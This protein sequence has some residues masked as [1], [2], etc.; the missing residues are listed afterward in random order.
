MTRSLEF[1][2]A[3]S[4]LGLVAASPGA[5]V[6]QVG[7]V[8]SKCIVDAENA[9]AEANWI[10]VIRYAGPCGSS[11]KALWLMGQAE[12]KL[13]RWV[14]AEE[15]LRAA[16]AMAGDS[17]VEKNR[18][19]LQ[20][21]L[22]EVAKNIGDLIVTSNIDGVRIAINERE[23]GLAPVSVRVNAGE[24]LVRARAEGRSEQVRRLAVSAGESSTASFQFSTVGHLEVSCDV[25]GAEIR[26]NGQL[27]GV[28]PLPGALQV[29]PGRVAV[30]ASAPGYESTRMLVDVSEGL[31]PRSVALKL[32]PLPAPGPGV[33]AEQPPLFWGSTIAA[34]ATLVAGIILSSVLQANYASFQAGCQG[35]D[36]NPGCGDDRSTMEGL[37]AAAWVL[38]TLS[39]ASGGAAYYF[40]LDGGGASEAGPSLGASAT[41]T[42]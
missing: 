34:G 41:F 29:G 42:F 35:Q 36:P 12:V 37:R 21:T 11:A 40:Y 3:A 28:T 32:V 1:A 27:V 31:G 26:L 38:L 25:S 23:I 6:A 39:V 22:G 10:D 33:D 19:T 7:A 20:R 2:V 24:V 16:L 9:K 13:G 15:H 17:W 18:E 5:V 4:F 30:E 8:D 14:D